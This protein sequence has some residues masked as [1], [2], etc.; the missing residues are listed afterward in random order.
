MSDYDNLV[1][2]LDGVIYLDREEIPGA[3][4]VL[5]SASSAGYN[6]LFATNNA[7]QTRRNLARHIEDITGYPAAP[8][9]VF[10]SAMAAASVLDPGDSCL[11]VA[12][13]GVTEAIEDA[14]CEVVT[15]WRAANSVIV[16]FDVEMTYRRLRDGALAIRAGARFIATNGDVTFPTPI[17]LWPGAGA[18]VSFLKTATD[19]TPEVVAGKPNRPF[20]DLL[21][22]SL[23]AG[24]TMVIGDRPETDLAMG[25]RQGWTTTLVL[26]GVVADASQ[27]PDEFRPDFV[28]DSVADLPQLLGL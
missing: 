16:G 27:V 19:R 23:K 6:V 11:A 15:D 18:S 13:A 3:G 28:L 4:G 26:S 5:R 22:A 24:Q 17:G 12:G 1:F 14:G 10:S 8:S 7:S 21:S 9:Q 2:D 20:Q 25:T